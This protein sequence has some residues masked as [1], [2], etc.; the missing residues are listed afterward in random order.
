MCGRR[1]R[2]RP[3]PSGFFPGGPNSWRAFCPACRRS[4]RG[5]SG[6]LLP[7]FL[8]VLLPLVLAV[9]PLA[10]LLQLLANRYILSRVVV[11]S[12][13]RARQFRRLAR[14][15]G[16]GISWAP[17]F[18]QAFRPTSFVGLQARQAFCPA[19]VW[20]PSGLPHHHR[21]EPQPRR[22]FCRLPLWFRAF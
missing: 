17:V 4:F 13:R 19:C 2:Y 22:V 16:F 3:I 9:L 20:G 7:L 18:H 21:L 10:P 1:R 12:V 11:I 8:L 14:T 6:T 5:V 15:Q